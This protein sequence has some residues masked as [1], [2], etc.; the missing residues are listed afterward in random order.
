MPLLTDVRVDRR[1]RDRRRTTIKS[2]V[3]G[4]VVDGR[5]RGPR[6]SADVGTCYLDWHEPKLFVVTLAIFLLNCL[7]AFFTLVLL[8][9][10]AEE[11]NV[12]MAALLESGTRTFV[13]VKLGITAIALLCLVP[14]A[15]RRLVGFVHVRHLL[16]AI[17][18]SYCVLVFY[19]LDML[20]TFLY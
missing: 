18:T 20:T 14:H 1:R 4:S 8:G 5:R 15:S 11:V 7:D 16:Y 3:L 2:L 13:N 9:L 19:Q 10:G 6:R 12:V 17:L